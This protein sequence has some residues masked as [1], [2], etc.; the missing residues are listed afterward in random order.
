MRPLI[1]IGL[2]ALLGACGIEPITLQPKDFNKSSSELLERTKG[3]LYL[4]D[5]TDLGFPI[6]FD[7]LSHLEP[8]IVAV[9]RSTRR[10]PVSIKVRPSQ[11]ATLNEVQKDAALIH[12]LGHCLLGLN[13]TEQVNELMSFSVQQSSRCLIKYGPIECINRAKFLGGLND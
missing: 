4:F 13:H 2:I 8:I 11:W 5:K 3:L 10:G 7:E 12:E 6:Y 9:C 1:L